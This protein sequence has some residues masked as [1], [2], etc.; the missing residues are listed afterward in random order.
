MVGIRIV[1]SAPARGLSGAKQ[2]LVSK[3]GGLLCRL[4]TAV[5]AAGCGNEDQNE[6]F[7]V[8]KV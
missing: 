2:A 4:E 3:T 5:I 1:R 7:S 6:F 8:K